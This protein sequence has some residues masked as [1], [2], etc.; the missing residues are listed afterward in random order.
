[1]LAGPFLLSLSS[2]CLQ[3]TRPYLRPAQSSC[4]Q[5]Q[6]Y[7]NPKI[8]ISTF[9]CDALL[10]VG[11][12]CNP[13][14]IWLLRDG[15]VLPPE[16]GCALRRKHYSVKQLGFLCPFNRVNGNWTPPPFRQKD[17]RANSSWPLS[18]GSEHT[19]G[20]HLQMIFVKVSTWE[21]SFSS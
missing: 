15:M 12:H 11:K 6:C 17:K 1:M 3:S 4:S 8:R 9:H 18:C 21:K 16:Q 19:P 2:W 20:R 7:L 10:M 14:D 13:V 5:F